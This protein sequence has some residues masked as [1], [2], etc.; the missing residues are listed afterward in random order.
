MRMQ[1]AFAAVQKQA[2]R[3]ERKATVGKGTKEPGEPDFSKGDF[4]GPLGINSRK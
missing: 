2:G 3:L 1:W 4:Q